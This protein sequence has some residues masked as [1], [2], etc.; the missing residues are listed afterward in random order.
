METIKIFLNSEKENLLERAKKNLKPTDP[1]VFCSIC[2]MQKSEFISPLHTAP[3]LLVLDCECERRLKMLKSVFEENKKIYWAEY[4]RWLYAY[5]DKNDPKVEPSKVR[6][7][8][9]M[10]FLS[11][12]IK[13]LERLA[14][15]HG[16]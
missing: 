6:H 15:I 11:N 7:F 16:Q 2:G 5:A 14:Q 9:F 1:P 12:E 10:L 3:K 13:H 4:S 8:K